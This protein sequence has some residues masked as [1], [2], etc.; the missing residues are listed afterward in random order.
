MRLF[1][2]E[3]AAIPGSN[4]IPVLH[5]RCEGGWQRLSHIPMEINSELQLQMIIIAFQFVNKYQYM[6]NM[7]LS[8]Y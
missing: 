6:Q 3:V 8:A 4:V 1:Y 5:V 2:E 7:Q